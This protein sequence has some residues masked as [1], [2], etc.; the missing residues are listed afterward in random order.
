V[1]RK[2]AALA[3]F[4]THQ[5]RHGV[6][7]GEL[8]RTWH[9]G[10]RRVWKS[11]LHHVSRGKPQARRTIKLR[12]PKKVPRVVTA[13]EMQAILD[14]CEHLRDRLL[15]ALLWDSGIRIGEALGL[16]HEDIAA[17]ERQ[18][19]IVPRLNANGMRAKSGGRIVPIDA[20]TVRLYGDYLHTEYGDLDSDYV[21]VNLWAQPLGQPWTYAAVYDLVKRLRVR[22]G[23]EF[24]PHWARHAYATR[25]LRDGVPI[26]VVSALLGHTSVATTTSIYGHLTVEDARAAL[27]AAG[28]FA[29]KE[30]SW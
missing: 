22:T 25:A 8:L 26:E 10:G 21:F 20:A 27:E 16:R 17:A 30:L 28:W 23:V 6:D 15:F 11:F 12:V 13:A 2:L 9:T 5:A 7:V 3:A 4:Y 1:S 29:G 19:T 14:A 18:L 24:D